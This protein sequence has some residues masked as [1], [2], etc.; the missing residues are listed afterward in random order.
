MQASTLRIAL[1]SNALF[2]TLSGLTVIIFSSSVADL[3]GV[4][5]P[6]SYQVI[7]VGLL[8][9]ACFVAWTGTQKPINAFLAALISLADFMWVVGTLL[10]IVL[11]FSSLQTAGIVSLIAIAAIVLF[12]GIRQLQGIGEMY[13]FPG[14]TNIHKMCVTVD[15]PEPADTMW[16]VIADLGNIQAY[17]PNLTKVIL[18]DN[19][20]PGVDTVRQCTDVNG[21]TWGEQCTRY[22]QDERSVAFQFL[23]DEPGF[24]YPFKT[25][26]GGWDVVPREDGSTIIIWFEVTPKY[27]FFHFIILAMMSRNMARSFGEVVARMT[28]AARGENIPT[29]ISLEQHGIRS[30][31]MACP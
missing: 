19:A 28:A 7:G 11:A 4:G 12:F 8:G 10:F 5:A 6:I 2:S 18:R 3:L 21:K 27:R 9:F 1:L 16:S 24:P 25:M 13:A 26:V 30:I 22:D 15:T 31:L 17:S 20:H 14:K 23:A 29:H